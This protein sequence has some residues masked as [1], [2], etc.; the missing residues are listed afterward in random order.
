MAE[1]NIAE[2]VNEGLLEIETTDVMTGDKDR[3]R[4]L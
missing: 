1:Y 2:E 4:F 3:N